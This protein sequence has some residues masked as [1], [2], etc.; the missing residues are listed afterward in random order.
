MTGEAL[1][2]AKH[3]VFRQA[4]ALVLEWH[5]GLKTAQAA[6]VTEV[7]QLL[8]DPDAGQPDL[9]VVD[10]E[11]PNG[12]GFELIGEIREAWPRV[13]VL[14]LTTGREPEGAA[15]AKEAGADEVLTMAASGEEL[16]EGVRR[17]EKS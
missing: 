10:L 11:L 5:A 16:L 9:A 4:L 13:P 3:V 1:L 14:V 7:H 15:R 2:V 8:G 6:S 17:L 12:E